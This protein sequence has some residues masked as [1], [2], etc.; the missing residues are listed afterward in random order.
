MYAD[1]DSSLSDG[2]YTVI[3]KKRGSTFVIITLEKL[4]LIFFGGEATVCKTVRSVL[5]DRYLSV[6]SVCNVGVLWPN[7]WMD[8]DETWNAGRTRPRP[9]CVR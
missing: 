3:H 2:I 4:V 6:L 9:H 5:S 7:A 8:Q 1:S